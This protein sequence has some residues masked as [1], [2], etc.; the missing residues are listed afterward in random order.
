MPEIAAWKSLAWSATGGG[1]ISFP[2]PEKSPPVPESLLGHVG[3]SELGTEG[4]DFRDKEKAVL[5]NSKR[6]TTKVRLAK[7]ASR[8]GS[9]NSNSVF[10]F[11]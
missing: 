10:G 11:M 7:N 1:K 9:N 4:S 2:P 3:V 6:P 5:K 8:K